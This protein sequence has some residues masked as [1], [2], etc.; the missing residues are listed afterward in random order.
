MPLTLM[1]A[2][3]YTTPS[4]MYFGSPQIGEETFPGLGTII[5]NQAAKTKR[6]VTT[7]SNPATLQLLQSCKFIQ[8]HVLEDELIQRILEMEVHLAIQDPCGMLQL[9]LGEWS[10]N[11]LLGLHTL[12]NSLG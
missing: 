12:C 8:E 1:G 10:S 5:F 4:T 6:P 2:S 11:T 9:L 7:R 3:S